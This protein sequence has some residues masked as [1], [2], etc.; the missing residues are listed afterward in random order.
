MLAEDHGADERVAEHLLAS[1]A[2][3]DRWVVER[4]VVA[5]R[6]AAHSGAPE[7]AA[8][9]LR[10]ALEEPPPPSERPMLMLELGMA[11]A[12]AGLPTWPSQ[13]QAAL[14]TATDDGA[15]VAAA[16]VLALRPRAR[17]ARRRGGRGARSR[18]RAA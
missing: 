1:D 3:G 14:E 11:E 12:S 15:R 16:M 13:L 5:A 9:Y 2:A 6:A 4:L 7:S 17:A 18:R 8:V 10:R